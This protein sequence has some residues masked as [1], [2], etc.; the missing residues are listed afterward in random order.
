MP[1]AGKPATAFAGA[2]IEFHLNPLGFLS[3]SSKR[4]R[5]R[6]RRRRSADDRDRPETPLP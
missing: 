4:V 2:R 5:I 1:W 3:N 6:R